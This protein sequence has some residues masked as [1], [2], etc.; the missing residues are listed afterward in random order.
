LLT[1]LYNVGLRLH[2]TKSDDRWI[3]GG[4]DKKHIWLSKWALDWLNIIQM[5]SNVTHRKRRVLGAPW[6][7]TGPVL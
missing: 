4:L 3:A 2:H 7:L 6:G 5:F 1:P